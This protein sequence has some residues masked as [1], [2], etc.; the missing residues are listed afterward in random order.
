MFHEIANSRNL[1]SQILEALQLGGQFA[2]LDFVSGNLDGF[3]KNMVRAGMDAEHARFRYPHMC[4]HSVDDLIDFLSES[5]FS[6][7]TFETTDDNSRAIVVG[8]KR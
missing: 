5:G 8:V 4:K 6:D 3:V 2:V 1:T 7:V